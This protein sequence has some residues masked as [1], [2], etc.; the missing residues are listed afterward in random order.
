MKFTT[1]GSFRYH[2]LKHNKQ[3]PEGESPLSIKE[4]P[5]VPEPRKQ[6]KL[7][8]PVQTSQPMFQELP[9]KQKFGKGDFDDIFSAPA[10]RFAGK[11]QWE[12]VN[13]E[14]EAT[15]ETYK[16]DDSQNDKY[17][18]VVEENNLLK[19]KLSTSE[20]VIKSMQKQINDLLGNLFAYQNQFEPLNINSAF[21]DFDIPKDMFTTQDNSE[22]GQKSE[23]PLL[24]MINYAEDMN[25][26]SP[27]Q[28]IF[29][30][31]N[32]YADPFLSFGNSFE[33]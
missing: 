20:K 28:P 2:V 6:V 31:E 3:L 16:S 30:K 33:F 7:E 27:S 8:T 22:N 19:Q 23:E 25:P 26:A 17:N 4:S 5:H 1:H 15:S 13:D 12:M 10:P 32:S 18:L 21:P 24:D 11:I 29:R 14:T 9:S